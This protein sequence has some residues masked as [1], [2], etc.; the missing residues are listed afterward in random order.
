MKTK[1]LT[2]AIVLT[3]MIGLSAC[4]KKEQPQPE[5]EPTVMELLT[6]SEWN[7]THIESYDNSGNLTGSSPY[8]Y[9]MELTNSG[10]YY[11]KDNSNN[12]VTYGTFSVNENADPK[13]IT[14]TPNSGTPG[15][16]QIITLNETEMKWKLPDAGGYFLIYFER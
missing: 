2:S 9:A 11:V 4:K 15:T 16:Y 10:N 7:S 6:K 14:L 5:P 13:T 8:N 3:L 12:M 1:L